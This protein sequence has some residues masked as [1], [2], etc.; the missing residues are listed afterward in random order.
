M[1]GQGFYNT[2]RRLVLKG[3]D[4]RGSA[5]R[6]VPQLSRR[7]VAGKLVEYLALAAITEP[8]Q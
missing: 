3:V 2:T 5:R 8:T 1:P 4:R 7:F 6:I